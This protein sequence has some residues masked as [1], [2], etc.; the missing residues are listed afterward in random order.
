MN[1]F[2]SLFGIFRQR[3]LVNTIQ[4]NK[5]LTGFI[6]S[7]ILISVLGSGLY[8][9]AMGA[10]LGMETAI[11]D[12]IKMILIVTLGLLFSIPVF[13]IAFRLLGREEKISQVAAIPLTLGATVSLLLAI[14][15]P[16]V[17]MLSVLAGFNP[18]AV[19]IHI[20]IIDLALLVG[21]YLAGTLVYHGFS[22]WKRLIIPNVVGFLMMG[23]IVI[24]LM[25]FLS[26]F[27]AIT[28]TFSVGTDRLKD[29]LG[30]GVAQKADQVLGAV[31]DADRIS[32]R[33]QTT[34]DNGDLTQDYTVARIGNNYLINIHLH[35]IPGETFYK[36]QRIWI[37]DGKIYT[38]F[39]GGRVNQM[40]RSEI[41]SFLDPAL[42]PG[43][44]T[45]PS[46]FSTSSWRAYEGGTSYS[47]TGTSAQQS[48]AVLI[49]DAASRKLISFTIGSS[50]KGVHA[51]TSVQEFETASLSQADLEISLS[52]AIV[53]GSGDS[54]NSSMKEFVQNDTFFILRYPNTW[55]AK[56][57]T[58][59]LRQIQ[60]TTN[61]GINI[62]CPNL[63][64]V[65]FDLAENKNA[66]QYAED[67]SDSLKLLPQYNDIAIQ[68]VSV[69][70]QMVTTV[71]Y[72]KAESVIGQ[73]VSQQ[74]IVYIFVGKSYRYHLDFSAPEENFETYRQLFNEMAEQFIYYKELP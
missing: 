53:L 25:N 61:C 67:L 33:F 72:I 45:L 49:L 64:A 59:S 74:H 55:Q 54:S 4:D 58:P 46:E 60:V 32:Y 31:A 19:Y 24:V 16:V 40:D 11:K 42:P 68:N 43:V 6:T 44:F 3:G 1:I 69:G 14:T 28:P 7:A 63:T 27:L 66:R 41:G 23:V 50:Q 20:I 65:V 73:Q 8:G 12:G 29:G 2:T 30:I 15:S 17:F 52:Q 39:E 21:L 62:V 38:D 70:D 57:W 71:M 51:G 22:D 47:I 36:D 56:S 18:D 26:P 37:L 10:G 5:P 48:Q 34:N 13:W 35:A 9:L